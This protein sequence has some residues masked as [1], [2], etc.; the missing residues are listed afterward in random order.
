LSGL[1]VDVKGFSVRNDSRSSSSLLIFDVSTIG[2]FVLFDRVFF[3]FLVFVVS[4][5]EIF[6]SLK[7]K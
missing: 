3:F 6:S 4:V 5:V 2:L 1:R 7:K